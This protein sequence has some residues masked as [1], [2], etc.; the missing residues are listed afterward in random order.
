MCHDCLVDWAVA[1]IGSLHVPDVWQNIDLLKLKCSSR[2]CEEIYSVDKLMQILDPGRF[3]QVSFALSRRVLQSSA[4]FIPCPNADCV[5]FG[6]YR[7][8]FGDEYHEVTC[9][10]PFECPSC[11]LKWHTQAQLHAK[12]SFFSLAYLKTLD[13][14]KLTLGSNLY[15]IFCSE[16]CPGCKVS[17]VRTGGCPFMECAKCKFQFCWYCLDQFYTEYHYNLTNCPFRYGLLH[18][19]EAFGVILLFIK[20]LTLSTWLQDQCLFLLSF[21]KLIVVQGVFL[22]QVASLHSLYK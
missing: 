17:I 6:F 8:Q 22:A 1:T 14:R 7:D 15:K 5:S 12:L 4:D 20:V 16:V 11:E 21:S 19:I 18:G 13:L 10:A 3:E 2:N 9:G